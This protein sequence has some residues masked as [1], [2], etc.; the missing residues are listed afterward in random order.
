MG[1]KVIL[2]FITDCGGGTHDL[3]LVVS[4]DLFITSHQ[5][6]CYGART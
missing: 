5:V 2:F 3:S 4:I 1:I 6:S